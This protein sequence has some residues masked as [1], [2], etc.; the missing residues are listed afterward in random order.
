MKILKFI[1]KPFSL[2]DKR[3]KWFIL[4]YFGALILGIWHALPNF[5]VVGDEWPYVVA[6][7]QAFKAHTI[8][9]HI[10]YQY[11][12]SWYLNYL[13]QIP[14]L[15]ILLIFLKGSVSSLEHFLVYHQEVAYYVPRLVTVLASIYLVSI[16]FLLGRNNALS[17]RHVWTVASL[18]FTSIIFVAMAHTGKMWIVSLLLFTISFYFL[19][20]TLRNDTGL[21]RVLPWHR[22]PLFY[23][24]LFPFLALANFSLNI[25]AM[26][27]IAALMFLYRKDTVLL[28]K[29]IKFGIVGS[30]VFLTFFLLNING[31]LDRSLLLDVERSTLGSLKFLFLYTLY[32]FPF[33]SVLL[34]FSFFK[35]EQIDIRIKILAVEAFVYGALIFALAPWVGVWPQM[36]LRY[37]LYLGFIIALMLL[38]L[39]IKIWRVAYLMVFVS[40]L[41][42]LKTI[43]LLSVPTTYNLARDYLIKNAG[44]S[45]VIND[46]FEVNLPK[47]QAAY[48]LTDAGGCETRCKYILEHGDDSREPGLLV[49]DLKTDK[50]VLGKFKNSASYIT[51]LHQSL[52]APLD[53]L[54]P[55]FI[56]SNSLQDDHFVAMEFG[57]GEYSLDFLNSSR[58][59]RPIYVFYSDKTP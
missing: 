37:L 30:L 47:N 26:I 6:V 40:I 57:L 2:L 22:N 31:W 21:L 18:I 43:F 19:D 7:F 36:Y 55:V 15:A 14:F 39:D 12:I 41:F 23:A 48:K 5:N 27:N 4:G 25:V 35:T 24:V 54:K 17:K 20:L 58:L 34:A 32:T 11:T 38:Y 53:N 33:L 42:F 56:A 46:L 9:P 8:I 45:L 10:I 52:E 29:I 51:S 50:S 49:A 59:G 13:F 28:K 16:F 44:G 3:E 1:V